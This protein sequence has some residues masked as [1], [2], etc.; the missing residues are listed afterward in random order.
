MYDR[1][2]HHGLCGT[3]F[4]MTTLILTSEQSRKIRES[5]ETVEIRDCFGRLQ[6]ILTACEDEKIT[7]TSEQVGRLLDRMNAPVDNMR[8]TEE[9]LAYLASLVHPGCESNSLSRPD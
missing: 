6:G 8:T 5:A 2:V 1:A 9:V 4:R 3:G 7:L